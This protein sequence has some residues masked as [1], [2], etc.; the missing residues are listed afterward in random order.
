[1]DVPDEGTFSGVTK[2]E[3]IDV[4]LNQEINRINNENEKKDQKD[5]KLILSPHVVN[6]YLGCATDR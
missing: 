6:K 1:M 4:D 5:S 3:F 2:K